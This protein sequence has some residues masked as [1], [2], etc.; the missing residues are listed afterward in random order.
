MRPGLN[1]PQSLLH[2]KDKRACLFDLDKH[3]YRI[4]NRQAV[5]HRTSSHALRPEDLTWVERLTI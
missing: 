5:M 4:G 2:K 3:R 1:V